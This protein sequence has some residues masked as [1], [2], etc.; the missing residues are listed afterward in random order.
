MLRCLTRLAEGASPAVLEAAFKS[1]L[2]LDPANVQ[3]KH[4]LEALMRNTGGIEDDDLEVVCKFFYQQKPDGEVAGVAWDQDERI[5][6]PVQFI[7]DVDSIRM[8]FRHIA[9]IDGRDSQNQE[10]LD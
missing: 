4:N 5:T 1:V 8:R 6:A 7:V 3:A 10:I 9:S 2:E